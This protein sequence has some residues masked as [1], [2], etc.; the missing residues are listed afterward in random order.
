M[1]VRATGGAEVCPA[2]WEPG[3]PIP[4]VGPDLVGNVWKIWKPNE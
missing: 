2:G 3:Q 1:H 4:K